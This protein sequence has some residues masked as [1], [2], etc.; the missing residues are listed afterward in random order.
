MT[1]EEELAILRELV[2]APIRQQL[3][4]LWWYRDNNTYVVQR[5]H[6]GP[7]ICRGPKLTDEIYFARQKLAAEREAAMTPNER[8]Y[9]AAL[10]SIYSYLVGVYGKDHRAVTIARE[11]LM[12]TP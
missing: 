2:D 3:R 1:I 8:K 12:E 4:D 11:A 6:G 5:Q 7:T 10:E 9:K